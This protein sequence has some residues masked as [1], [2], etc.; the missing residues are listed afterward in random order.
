MRRFAG[1]WW[2]WMSQFRFLHEDWTIWFSQFFAAQEVYRKSSFNNGWK[3][4]FLI[5]TTLLHESMCLK[6]I[7]VCLRGNF[8]WEDN[9]GDSR[10]LFAYKVKTMAVIEM[11]DY[12]T[13]P[14][15]PSGSTI[16]LWNDRTKVYNVPD[17]ELNQRIVIPKN[18]CGIVWGILFFS[19]D[20]FFFLVG[21]GFGAVQ[22]PFWENPGVKRRFVGVVLGLPRLRSGETSGE[23]RFHPGLDT[24]KLLQTSR[25]FLF[26]V[27]IYLCWSEYVC[28]FVI[29]YVVCVFFLLLFWF[30]IQCTSFL[31]FAIYLFNVSIYFLDSS[32]KNKK[33]FKQNI[34]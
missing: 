7:F 4:Q 18:G 8:R 17:N 26:S 32:F 3:R 20:F 31:V 6:T 14:R 23:I 13:L 30:F 5:E 12:K 9:C 2:Q 16:S 11:P 29:E 25:S 27:C 21:G 24:K 19:R 15:L 1:W 33:D 10:P 28:V 22:A 34:K